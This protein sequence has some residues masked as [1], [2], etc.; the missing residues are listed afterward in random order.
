[1]C[2]PSL[3]KL[4]ESV[5]VVDNSLTFEKK[6][7]NTHTQAHTIECGIQLGG[8]PLLSPLKETVASQTGNC[9]QNQYSH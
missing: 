3:E 2:S 1:M 7:T 4:F 9:Y 5:N 8:L 6:K